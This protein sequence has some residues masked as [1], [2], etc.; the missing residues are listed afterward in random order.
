MGKKR[1]VG[2]KLGDWPA[3]LPV[4]QYGRRAVGAE[5]AVIKVHQDWMGRHDK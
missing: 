5:T 1:I 2:G 3:E 4:Y